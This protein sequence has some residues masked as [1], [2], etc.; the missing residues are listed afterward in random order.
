MD[1]SRYS[2]DISH[3]LD[4]LLFEYF[5]TLNSDALFWLTE[6]DTW[7]PSEVGETVGSILVTDGDGV[8]E[9]GDETLH[10]SAERSSIDSKPIS[11]RK[12]GSFTGASFNIPFT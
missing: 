11:K 3:V 10:V 9:A 12:L 5:D 7:L 1:L 2:L 6:I 4:L 8:I